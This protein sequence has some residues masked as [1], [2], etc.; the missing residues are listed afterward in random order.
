MYKQLTLYTLST[1]LLLT[2]ACTGT[3]TDID[4]SDLTGP[5]AIA[6]PNAILGEC[7]TNRAA[8]SS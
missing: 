4:D 7:D 2:A 6:Q 3:S 1:L 8:V 5:N